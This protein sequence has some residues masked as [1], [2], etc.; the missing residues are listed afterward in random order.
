MHV[1]PNANIQRSKVKFLLIIVAV[2]TVFGLFFGTQN[3]IRDI[4]AGG[5][6]SLPGYIIGWIFCGYSWGILTIP[7]LRFIRRYSFTRLGWTRFA[8]VQLP[9]AFIFSLTQLGIYLF[10]A[11][12]LFRA[13]GR[14]LWEFYKFL[15]ANELQSS[16]LVYVTIVAAVTVYDRFFGASADAVTVISLP[17]APEQNSPGHNSL[18]GHSNGFLKRFSVKEN[19]RIVLV[20]T[21]QID[22][23]ESYGNYLFVH[24]ADGKFI[25]RETMAGME[26]KLDPNEFVR[27]R[28]SAIVKIDR[29]REFH[30]VDNGEFE[31]VL[32]NGTV[33]SSTRR[34]KRNLE[35]ILKA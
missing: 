8:L 12:V 2:W 14:G 29:I 3:Y 10:I 34:Y 27:I 15:L 26:S 19:G 31:V 32:E 22:W 4:Y 9:A 35:S 1:F 7:G 23:I 11:G 28:R 17:A 20:D 30:P 18:I 5:P 21:N 16:V 24:T 25:H 13:S 6:A 33:L